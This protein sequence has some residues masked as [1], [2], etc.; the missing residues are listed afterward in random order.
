MHFFACPSARPFHLELPPF[1]TGFV[2]LVS[3]HVQARDTSGQDGPI[4]V[5]EVEIVPVDDNAPVLVIPEESVPVM[6]R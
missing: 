1:F 6:P 3:L 2:S 4:L 5:V